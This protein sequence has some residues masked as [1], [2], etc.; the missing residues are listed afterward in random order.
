MLIKNYMRIELER[1]D[2]HWS[3]SLNKV[4]ISLSK[5]FT[6]MYLNTILFEFE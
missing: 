3:V 5:L 4:A 1:K 2:K 6:A